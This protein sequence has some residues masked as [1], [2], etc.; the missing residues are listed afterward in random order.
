VRDGLQASHFQE[1][2]A[3]RTLGAQRSI[4]PMQPRESKCLRPARQTLPGIES[5]GV[6]E[7]WSWSVPSAPGVA[8]PR[9]WDLCFMGNLHD[10][11]CRV[12]PANFTLS[13]SQNV[14]LSL[15]L[16][17]LTPVLITRLGR[18]K[19]VWAGPLNGPGGQLERRSSTAVI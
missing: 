13:R 18:E 7:R 8:T 17:F 2:G 15:D 11:N 19:G 3:R 14:N 4:E 9:V 10:C 5:Y 12:G 16:R 1:I 6:L